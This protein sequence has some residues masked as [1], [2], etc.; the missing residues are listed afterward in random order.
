MQKEKDTPS[1]ILKEIQC[2]T[3]HFYN[4]VIDRYLATHV[5]LMVVV[6][7]RKYKLLWN[8]YPFAKTKNFTKSEEMEAFEYGVQNK[9]MHYYWL[10]LVW[11]I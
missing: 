10:I 6:W 2:T 7:G 3:R 9:I 1:S 4:A 11:N 5:C 8:M